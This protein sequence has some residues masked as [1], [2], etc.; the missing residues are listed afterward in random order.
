LS[1]RM[2]FS[3]KQIADASSGSEILKGSGPTD[4]LMLP[5]RTEGTDEHP[6]PLIIA[7]VAGL[8]LA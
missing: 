6:A 4:Y 5:V 7:G 1:E 3:L 8:G 2:P